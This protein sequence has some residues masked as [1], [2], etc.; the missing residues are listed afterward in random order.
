MGLY[1]GW[2]YSLGT[3]LYKKLPET[4]RMNL[5]RFKVFLFYT[6]R[7][8]DIPFSIYVWFLFK[9][10]VR[11]KSRDIPFDRSGSFIFNVLYFLLFV[12]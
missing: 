1:F 12:F 11:S 10:S 2:F 5:T 6:H 8:Y 9:E 7:V 3:N 4:E